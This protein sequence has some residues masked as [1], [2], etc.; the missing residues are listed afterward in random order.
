MPR[1][2]YEILGVGR[3]APPEEIK[4]AYRRLAM[5]YH[6]DKNPGDKEAEEKFKE[7]SEAYAALSDAKKRETYDRFGPDAFRPGAGG[8]AG[9]GGVRM[10]HVDLNDLFASVFG[11]FGFGGGLDDLLGRGRRGGRRAAAVRGDDLESAVEMDFL[12]AMRG[13]EVTLDVERLEACGDC[14]GTGA[15]KGAKPVPCKRCGGAGEVRNVQRSIFGQFVSVGTCPACSGRGETVEHPCTGCRGTGR[16]R[17]HRKI[18]IKVPAGIEDGM[19][20]RVHGEG[21]AGPHGGP[22]GDLHLHVRIR[23][24]P[25]F[26]RADADVRVAVP[27]TF[28][29]AALGAEVEIPTLDGRK[30]VKVAAGTQPG[31]EVRLRGEGPPNVHSGRKGDLV[32]EILVEVPTRLTARQREALGAFREAS[33]EAEGHPKTGAF[34]DWLKKT[35]GGA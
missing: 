2:F 6:P 23:P 29:Q 24:H 5:R 8:G 14:A 26:R 35:I 11:G 34:L 12:D 1:D 3:E 27:V 20:I 10:E 31:A 4:K 32:V 17:A 18:S 13:A 30:R 15:P 25:H 21:D 9:F 33:G 7:I 16:E 22:A 28:P 19:I